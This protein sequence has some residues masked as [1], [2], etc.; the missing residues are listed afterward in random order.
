[1]TPRGVSASRMLSTVSTVLATIGGR[2]VFAAFALVGL[3]MLVWN[4]R[5]TNAMTAQNRGFIEGLGIA[6]LELAFKT[7]SSALVRACN[8]DLHNFLRRVVDRHLYRR[9]DP[10]LG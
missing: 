8:P 6:R 3:A 7:R 5:L 2:I 10:W 1:V 4:R 9:R